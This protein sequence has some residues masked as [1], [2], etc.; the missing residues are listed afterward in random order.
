MPLYQTPCSV[1]LAVRKS[2][3]QQEGWDAGERWVE[4]YHSNRILQRAR[5]SHLCSS[6]ASC[7]CSTSNMIPPALLD[8][9]YGIHCRQPASQLSLSLPLSVILSE[10]VP[11]ISGRAAVLYNRP[12]SSHKMAE[13]NFSTTKDQ[14]WNWR[15]KKE[16]LSKNSVRYRLH[17]TRSKLCQCISC[18]TWIENARAI[19]VDCKLLRNDYL[20]VW[21]VQ[22]VPLWSRWCHCLQ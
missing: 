13:Q 2:G 5:S 22:S 17:K 10:Q 11:K 4:R 18:S 16:V 21:N 12:H 6:T 8:L 1:R 7:L 9:T 20:L 14:R 19:L 15:R 3:K